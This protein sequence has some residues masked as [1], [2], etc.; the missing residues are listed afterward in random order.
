MKNKDYEVMKLKK[1]ME[2]LKCNEKIRYE[3]LQEE[4]KKIANLLGLTEGQN[5]NVLLQAIEGIKVRSQKVEDF[6]KRSEALQIELE[7]EKESGSRL[8]E[9]QHQKWEQERQRLNAERYRLIQE[10][11]NLRK[12]TPDSK[13]GQVNS[14]EMTAE[15]MRAIEADLDKSKSLIPSA[16]SQKHQIMDE[17]WTVSDN[18]KSPSKR[19]RIQKGSGRSSKRAGKNKSPS[20]SLAPSEL[21]F[22]AFS[23][24]S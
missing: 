7:K 18:V 12:R 16:S 1:E 13:T 3:E 2:L 15:I 14:S 19:P 5:I 20:Q 22:W 21:D 4:M 9:E 8:L 23:R 11:E 24:D 10:N 17:S 6:E